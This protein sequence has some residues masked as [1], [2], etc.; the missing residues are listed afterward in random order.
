M[1]KG[2]FAFL[3]SVILPKDNLTEVSNY[4]FENTNTIGV[5]Y[6]NIDRIELPRIQT[7][8]QTAIGEVLVK[9]S[10]T[11]TNTIKTKPEFDDVKRIAKETNQSAFQVLNK[12]NN[13][14][15]KS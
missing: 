7:K 6:F 5:R 15:L 4:I 1:K 8:K 14:P 9:E 12:I 2:R 3:L 13:N 10:T 11:P